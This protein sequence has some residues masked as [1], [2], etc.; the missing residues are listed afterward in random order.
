MKNNTYDYSDAPECV[1]KF[2]T[3]KLVI[4]NRSKLT[5]FNYYHD[6]RTFARFLLSNADKAKYSRVD[7]TDIPFSDATD[8]LFYKVKTLD[9][10]NFLHYVSNNNEATSRARKLSCLR[11][12]YKYLIG[13]TDEIKVNPTE[14]IESPK[15]KK[16]LP[17]YLSLE[18]SKTLLESVDGKNAERDFA[19]ITL[20][21]NCGL[22]VSELAGINTTDF[23]DDL[24]TLVV[25]GKGNKQRIVYLNNACKDAVKAYMKIRPKDVKFSDRNALFISRN[26]NRIS[27]KTV[28]WLIYKHLDGAGLGHLNMS[29]HKLRH[30]A[31]TLMYNYGNTDVRV[32]KEILGHEDLSTTQI[33]THVSESKFSEAAN[34]NPLSDG[35][36]RK[37][38]VSE[39]IPDDEKPF[40]DDYDE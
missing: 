20:F 32:L 25:T 4:Q 34:N 36:K 39:T 40:N 22:R 35:V 9:I 23:S 16:T 8:E 17:K 37:K 28:Q 21:L 5:V 18:Q 38:K 30:T 14:R 1:Q 13:N 29:V 26:R 10:M 3:Y 33:Y 27:I 7:F 31:A 12:F 24:D 2:L 6:L 11:S 15:K 19:I